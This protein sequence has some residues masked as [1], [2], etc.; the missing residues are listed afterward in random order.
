MFRS[1]FPLDGKRPPLQQELDALFAAADRFELR[2]R[3]GSGHDGAIIVAGSGDDFFALQK[4]LQI[5]EDPTS[6]FHCMCR[7]DLGLLLKK[8]GKTTT[9]L[10][11]HHGIGI[12]HE[13]WDSDADLLAPREFA[14]FLDGHGMA[15]QLA[16]F[17]AAEAAQQK[18]LQA[19]NTFADA[20][21][22]C[23]HG[24]ARSLSPNAPSPVQS[25]LDGPVAI[26]VSH[27]K[28]NVHAAREA[29]LR[30]S[31]A[32]TSKWDVYPSYESVPTDM[33]ARLD[34]DRA[35]ADHLKSP[36]DADPE[37]LLGL[38]RYIALRGLSVA[39]TESLARGLSDATRQKMLQLAAPFDVHAR[40]SRS[41]DEQALTLKVPHG[42]TLE[43]VFEED[44]Y[45]NLC[46]DGERFY[47]VDGNHIVR[48]DP[49]ERR[50]KRIC[51]VARNARIHLAAHGQRIVVAEDAQ[52]FCLTPDGARR[53]LLTLPKPPDGLYAFAEH[54][55]WVTNSDPQN[56]DGRTYSMQGRAWNGD[57]A[58]VRTLLPPDPNP[59]YGI[60]LHDGNFYIL[61]RRKKRGFFGNTTQSVVLYQ[62][63]AA[64]FH[65]EKPP[66]PV[67]RHDFRTDELLQVMTA[68]PAIDAP[69]TGEEKPGLWA[70]AK[71]KLFRI[72]SAGRIERVDLDV[73]PRRLAQ[74]SHGPVFMVDR[75]DHLRIEQRTIWRAPRYVLE[76][77]RLP[78]PSV[79]IARGDDLWISVGP[80]VLRTRL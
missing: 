69:S 24:F 77:P 6:G 56:P 41:L 67:E 51:E 31:G 15:G 12:R 26:L 70:F 68:T 23:L 79:M 61:Q 37:I 35:I 33:L 65:D 53:D 8:G 52:I 47:G 5:R 48:F 11:L 58:K 7:G 59:P 44:R 22:L 46:C 9:V 71:K 54:I 27:E 40:L 20:A 74:T 39:G 50:P 18:Y 76:L 72:P 10:G 28:G 36:A 17:D 16:T 78:W 32:S 2:Q 45:Y 80:A 30:W 60:C 42:A 62:L 57:D 73:E 3:D 29:L 25:A 75:G 43:H 49:G 64:H 55:V 14:A 66:A 21:P 19:R 63:D 34:F 38:A 1:H 4:A 13:G